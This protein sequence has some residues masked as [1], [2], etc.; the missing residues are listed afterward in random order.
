MIFIYSIRE[1][2][3]LEKE[4]PSLID[5]L[6]QTS[7]VAFVVTQRYFDWIGPCAPIQS[8]RVTAYSMANNQ[9][10]PVAMWT[11]EMKDEAD[12]A[13]SSAKGT[14]KLF[15]V[16]IVILLLCIGGFVYSRVSMQMK[17]NDDAFQAQYMEDPHVGDILYCNVSDRDPETSQD[18]ERY[19]T[20]YR[21][22]EIDN[23]TVFVVKSK[24]K[25][26]VALLILK[27]SKSVN[28]FNTADNTFMPEVLKFKKTSL[29]KNNLLPIA[30]GNRNLANEDF[31]E[32]KY[33]KRD[34]K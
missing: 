24:E 10:I 7:G 13:K 4:V 22:V 9:P 29:S 27:P 8:K 21:I 14:W 16:P 28:K 19:A 12:R 18:L 15:I 34:S 17:N 30:T 11:P 6:T 23:D 2:V 3:F 5:P 25:L 33:R 32:V 26:D 31:I 1:K 20:V